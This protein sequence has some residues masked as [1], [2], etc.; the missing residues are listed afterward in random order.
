MSDLLDTINNITANASLIQHFSGPKSWIVHLA[1][2]FLRIACIILFFLCPWANSQLIQLFRTRSFYM[3]SS[4]KWYVIFKAIFDTL[5][6]MISIPVMFF[7]TFEIDFIHLNMF[8]CKFITYLHY[9]SDDLI[10][11]LLTFLC[12]DRM[13]R[14]TLGYRLRKR[15]SL[16]VCLILTVTFL[17]LNIHRL[18]HSEHIDGACHKVYTSI[19]DYNF[20]IYYSYIFI[21]ITWLVILITSINVFVS[22]Y[23]DRVR[24]KKIRQQQPIQGKIEKN[25]SL[26]MDSDRLGLID[27]AGNDGDYLRLSLLPRSR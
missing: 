22:V 9:T 1:E 6:T 23:C 21:A 13:I 27:S 11:I 16:T 14:I 17:N 8:T 12:I 5:F 20:D 24:N 4:A 7:L 19:W 10:S 25:S 15:C 3:E 2:Y 18:G 26:Q